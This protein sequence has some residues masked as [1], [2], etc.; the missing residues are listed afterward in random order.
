MWDILCEQFAAAFSYTD[1]LLQNRQTSD[2]LSPFSVEMLNCAGIWSFV[3]SRRPREWIWNIGQMQ[4]VLCYLVCKAISLLTLFSRNAIC[5]VAVR[6]QQ[7]ARSRSSH[8]SWCYWLIVK[9]LPLRF[10]L[11]I[12]CQMSRFRSW[13]RRQMC[14][15]PP[16]RDRTWL[17][18]LNS[19]RQAITSLTHSWRWCSVFWTNCYL[20]F[21]PDFVV[22]YMVISPRGLKAT[23]KYHKYLV[24]LSFSIK[25]V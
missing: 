4:L 8:N 2:Y 17:I 13:N 7:S 1:A 5:K 20:M 25:R 9:Y 3:G 12:C 21:L 14:R 18:P 22:N 19:A 16:L 10:S 11:G 15:Q 24:F 6:K 23:S